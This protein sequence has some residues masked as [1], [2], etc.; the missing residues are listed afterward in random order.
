MGANPTIDSR[1][2]VRVWT[3]SHDPVLRGEIE[4][5]TAKKVVASARGVEELLTKLETLLRKLTA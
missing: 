1:Y 3:E 4:D 2:I 5:V